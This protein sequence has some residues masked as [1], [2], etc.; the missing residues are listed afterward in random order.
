MQ[1]LDY[2]FCAMEADEP[3]YSHIIG[4]IVRGTVDR[5]LGT[6]HP[7]HLDIVYPIN[8]GYVDGVFA[9]DGAEQ[10]VYLDGEDLT[11]EKINE[12][13]HS[14]FHTLF[15]V[16]SEQCFCIRRETTRLR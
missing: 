8:Y 5:P 6:S 15:L 11:E 13:V 7:R 14:I 12:C 9:D 10:D 3:D 4:K 16:L 1:T 2:F